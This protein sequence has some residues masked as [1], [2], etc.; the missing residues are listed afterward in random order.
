MKKLEKDNGRLRAENTF[1]KKLQ[2][3]EGGDI[4]PNKTRK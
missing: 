4:N 2:E 3:L 1:L